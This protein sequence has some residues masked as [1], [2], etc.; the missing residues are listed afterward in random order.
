MRDDDPETGALVGYSTICS[1]Q[2]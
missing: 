1:F 2:A